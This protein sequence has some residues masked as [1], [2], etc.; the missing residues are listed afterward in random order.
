MDEK[1]LSDSIKS[2]DKK[3][4]ELSNKHDDNSMGQKEKTKGP[5]PLNICIQFIASIVIGI[6]LG[7]FLDEWLNT[8]PWFLII[9]FIVGTVTSFY[10]IYRLSK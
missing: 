1:E 7:N 9:C 10:N 5:D 3:L 8:K 4:N 2:L 6:F